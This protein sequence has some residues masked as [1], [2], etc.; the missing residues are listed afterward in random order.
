MLSV[1]QIVGNSVI[2]GTESHLLDLVQGLG[3]SG[4]HVEVICPR[5][6]PLTEQLS[7]LDVRVQCVEMVHPWPNGEYLLDQ[8][9]ILNLSALI[10]RKRPDIIHSHLY[11][12]YLHASLAAKETSVRAIVNTAHN[13]IIRPRDALLSHITGAHTI[14]IS[15]SIALLLK[16]VGV[17]VESIEVI[18]KGI[19]PEHFEDN[20]DAQQ[21]L[22]MELGLE[23][24]PIIGTVARLSPEKGIDTFLYA[25]RE[26][27]DIYP[28]ITGLVIG[29]GPQAT[30]LSHLTHQLGLE[31]VVHFSG[32]RKDTPALNRLFDIFVLPSRMETFSMALLEA[33]AASRTV[34]ATNVGGTTEVV[35]HAVDGWLVPPDDPW[36]LSRAILM[37]LKHPAR[38]AAMGAVA[39]RK[40]A[41]HFTRDRM[42]QQ[43]LA[44]YERILAGSSRSEPLWFAPLRLSRR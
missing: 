12:A 39:H 10:K 22:R 28:N 36:T 20:F 19:G 1:M 29:D 30:E 9:A 33:M 3:K 37:L 5:P 8:E 31:D 42:I 23:N 27:A 14:A 40:V 38:R 44:F 15:Q 18:H 43:T 35:T 7:S 32:A 11:P 41:A 17:P 16:G 34:V 21:S 25:M 4:V 2:G 26:V 13:G 6:G 24:G